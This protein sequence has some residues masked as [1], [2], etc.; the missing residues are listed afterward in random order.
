MGRSVSSVRMEVKR[1]AERWARTARTLKKEEQIYAT[2]LAEMAKRHS[3][4]VFYLFDDPLEAAV[5]SVLLELL[6]ALENVDSGLLLRT[7]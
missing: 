6:K 4:E 7:E 3:S 5:F 2:K 1:I